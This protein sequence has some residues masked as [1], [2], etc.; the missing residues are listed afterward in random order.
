MAVVLT[1]AAPDGMLEDCLDSVRAAEGLDH[2]VV[3]D[4]GRQARDRLGGRDV[5]LI[6][7]GDN[8]GF[9][10]GM[11]VGI[12]RGLELGA[13]AVLILNDDVV[14][15]PDFVGPLAAALAA[16]RRLGA[17]QPKLLLPGDDPVRVNSVGVVLGADGAGRDIGFGEP[18]GPEFS[19]D[20]EI[21]AFT[22]GAVLLRADF[23]R[24]VGLFDER[25]F[26]YY[27]DVD[28]ALSGAER[29]WRYRCITSSRVVHQGS[30]ST[31]HETVRDRTVFLRERNRLWILLRY[32]SVGDI[33]RGFWLS[34]RRLRWPPRG[35]H[36]RALLAGVG[37]V[38]RSW[39]A[40]RRAGRLSHPFGAV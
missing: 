20:R 1:F 13:D 24:E 14:V 40:R 16:D 11:N 33:R 2:V 32:R 8:L 5:E 22:G 21:E 23:L 26:L 4:N 10:G 29:G 27:E 39:A 30:V 6:V 28:L 15:E 36:A 37:A 19:G 9:A 31:L 38:P 3:V 18:D 35:V 7:S 25:F 17:V 34:V 12:R